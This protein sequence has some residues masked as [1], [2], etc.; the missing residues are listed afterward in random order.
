[1]A[2]VG[3]RLKMTLLAAGGVGDGL[4]IPECDARLH[5]PIVSGTSTFRSRFLGMTRA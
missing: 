1:M 5:S 3:D 2:R 4:Y